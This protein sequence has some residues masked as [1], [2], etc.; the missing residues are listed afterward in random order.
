MYAS[1]CARR[2]QFAVGKEPCKS[3]LY[4]S[5]SPGKEPYT[6]KLNDTY[7]WQC[8]CARVVICRWKSAGCVTVCCRRSISRIFVCTCDVSLLR[9]WF[10]HGTCMNESWY[11][12][13]WVMVPVWMSHGTCVD[14]IVHMWLIH[15]TCCWRSRSAFLFFWCWQVLFCVD[16]WFNHGTC[17]NE[18]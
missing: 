12:Y 7:V 4:H 17:I 10:N 13:E 6:I 5:K 1:V 3:A 16:R 14:G 2:S 8:S 9:R 11:M 18:I 15:V